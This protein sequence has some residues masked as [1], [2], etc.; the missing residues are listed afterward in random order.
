MKI[1]GVKVLYEGFE[2]N[3]LVTVQ[4]ERRA[5]RAYQVDDHGDGACVLAVDRDRRMALLIRQ[6]RVPLLYAGADPE[7]LELPG[8]I[9]EADGP[10]A[11]AAR[12]VLE[13]TGYAVTGL[14]PLG[15]FWTMPGI[16]T[17]RLHLYTADYHAG[18]RS[19][20]GGGL[21]EEGEDIVVVEIALAEPGRMLDAG[22]IP[23]LRTA[24]A[25]QLLRLRDPALFA[26]R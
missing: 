16:S 7:L 24:M 1:E 21:V 11:S 20:A 22:E 25:A 3:L 12:E 26:P 23:D 10:D 17:E 13:E 9:I 8:G 6:K 5:T 15:T 14:A 4:Q 2:D 19:G 18:S